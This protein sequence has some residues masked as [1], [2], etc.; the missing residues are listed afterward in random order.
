MLS[1][2]GSMTSRSSGRRPLRRKPSRSPRLSGNAGARGY[3]LK[4]AEP[5]AIIRAIVA[6]NEGPGNLRSGHCIPCDSRHRRS[7]V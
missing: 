4:D 6:V 7:H 2:D 3:L 5:D 1:L